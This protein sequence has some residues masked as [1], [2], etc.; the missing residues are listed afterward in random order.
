M[1]RQATSAVDGSRA[2]GRRSSQMSC[3]DQFTTYPVIA[4]LLGSL[5][6]T[7]VVASLFYQTN[8]HDPVTYATVPAVLTGARFLTCALPAWR[9][10]RVEPATALRA[11]S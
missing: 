1:S 2:S 11:D 10:G 5:A 6:L 7:R 3:F 4:G 8:A 9:A